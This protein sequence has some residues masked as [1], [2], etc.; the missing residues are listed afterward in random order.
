MNSKVCVVGSLNFDLVFRT[1]KLPV[2]GQTLL[3]GQF[4]THSGGKGGNQAVAIGTLGGIVDFIGSIGQDS[5]GKIMRATLD[6]AGVNT[7][8]LVVD[9]TTPSGTACVLVDDQGMN[10]IVVAAGANLTLSP[11]VVRDALA[12]SGSRVVLT[13]LEIP[14]DCV[15]AASEAEFF[16]L[17]PAPASMI[18]GQILARCRVLTPNETELQGLTGILPDDPEDC[19]RASRGLL[20]QGV[21]NVVVTLGSRGSYWVSNAGGWYFQAPNVRPVDTTAAGDAFNGALA[22]FLA[23]GREMSNAIQLANCVGALSTTKHGA[24]ESMPSLAELKEL[25]GNL[26]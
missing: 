12:Q 11:A 18:P 8:S 23:A 14:M 1:G 19:I 10:M 20:E 26:L 9:A 22:H 21:K 2:P 6:S 3:G 4:S 16:I 5:N 7:E 17:N 25:A 24:Q 15:A 13:Q